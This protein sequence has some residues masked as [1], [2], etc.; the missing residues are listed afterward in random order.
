MIHNPFL[1]LVGRP[2]VLALALHQVN[3]FGINYGV[4]V[5][6]A[7]VTD[8]SLV[9]D[10]VPDHAVLSSPLVIERPIIIMIIIIDFIFYSDS[11]YN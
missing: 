6:T 11:H 1:E 5:T 4:S 7:H 3:Y 8:H 10:P 2:N 9:V